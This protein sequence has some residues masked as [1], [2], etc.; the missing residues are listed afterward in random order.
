MI[1]YYPNFKPQVIIL[2]QPK[3]LGSNISQDALHEI[4]GYIH[5]DWEIEQ[6]ARNEHI[7]Y[8][9]RVTR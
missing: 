2:Y 6:D 7:S 5:S 4:S 1:K 3:E 8:V 9:K